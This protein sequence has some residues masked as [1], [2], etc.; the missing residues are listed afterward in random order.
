MSASLEKLLANRDKFR[1]LTVEESIQWQGQERYKHGLEKYK[2]TLDR[3]DLTFFE[4]I[5]HFKEE[6]F[7]ACRYAE[8]IQRDLEKSGNVRELL[9][10]SPSCDTYTQVCGRGTR[11]SSKV[12]EAIHE[13]G[14]YSFYVPMAFVGGLIGGI[15]LEIIKHKL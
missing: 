5:Q 13:L 2:V 10:P 4:W 8:C 6:C 14:W 1:H 15:L 7:D 12:S 9:R 3:T 11:V